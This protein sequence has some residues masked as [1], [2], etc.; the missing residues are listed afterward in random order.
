[1]A[2][3]VFT[4]DA[5]ALLRRV[6]VFGLAAQVADM[7]AHPLVSAIVTMHLPVGQ[8]A[9]AFTANPTDLMVLLVL[10]AILALAHIFHAAAEMA[11]DHAR[12]V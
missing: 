5:A 2:G 12:I 11:D 3:R 9:I 6:A 10:S 8:R 1:L 7:A 4:V